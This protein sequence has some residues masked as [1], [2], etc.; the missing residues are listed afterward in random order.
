MVSAFVVVSPGACYSPGVE[1]ARRFAKNE[2]F[3]AS[4]VVTAAVTAASAFLP[5]KYVATAVGLIFVGATWALVWR[6]DDAFVAQCGLTFAGLVLPGKL[7]VGKLL[8][9]SLPAVGWALVFAAI[10]FVPFWFGWR[11]WWNAR[12]SFAFS[13]RPMGLVNDGFGQLVMIALPEEAFYRGYLQS[14]FDMVWT[15]RVRIAGAVVGPGLLVASAI[16]A[17]GHLATVHH[18]ARLAVFFPALVFGWL[19]ARTRGVGAS[20]V[21]HALCNIFSEALGRGYGVY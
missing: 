11:W 9:G 12:G 4:V 2:A 18:P 8:R 19:R 21:F 15:P 20:V 13:P 17:L 14:R 5:D 3:L 10:A 6:K 7:D 1:S 16:F